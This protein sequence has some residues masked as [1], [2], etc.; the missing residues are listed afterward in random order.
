MWPVVDDA[1]SM[2]MLLFPLG[3]IVD[4]ETRAIADN[5]MAKTLNVFHIFFCTLFLL[6]FIY[7]KLF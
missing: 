4:E 7:L 1:A 6:F 3:S 2:S 5:K